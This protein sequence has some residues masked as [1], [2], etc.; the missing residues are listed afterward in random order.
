V[1]SFVLNMNIKCKTILTEILKNV[2]KG[3][4]TPSFEE[5]SIINIKITFL[6]ELLIMRFGYSTISR[7]PIS[8]KTSIREIGFREIVGKG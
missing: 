6:L 3:E 7:K 1:L 4:E 2:Y 5:N 8:G